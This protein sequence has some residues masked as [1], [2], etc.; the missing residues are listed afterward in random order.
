M[1]AQQ[2]EHARITESCLTTLGPVLDDAA[3]LQ[4]ALIQLHIVTQQ[5]CVHYGQD[6]VHSDVHLHII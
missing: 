1:E 5:F 2:V 6:I 3:E 4:Q